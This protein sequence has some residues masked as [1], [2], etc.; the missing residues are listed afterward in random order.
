MSLQF[1]FPLDAAA[2]ENEHR[3]RIALDQHRQRVETWF[4]ELELIDK[5]QLAEFL[6]VYEYDTCVALS[7]AAGSFR[8]EQHMNGK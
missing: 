7:A 6:A 2:E 1:A 5:A 4:E 8:A 3:R